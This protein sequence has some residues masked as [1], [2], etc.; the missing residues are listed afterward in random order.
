MFQNEFETFPLSEIEQK[1]IDDVVLQLKMLHIDNIV[2]FPF[3]TPP[4]LDQLE[5]AEKHLKLLEILDEKTARVTGLGRKVSQFPVTPRFGKMLV[6]GN[7]NDIL[8][9]VIIIVAALSVPVLFELDA[10]DSETCLEHRVIAGP[11]GSHGRKLGDPMLLLKMV[12]AGELAHS[13]GELKQFCTE[14]HIRLVP[15]LLF[16]CQ[17]LKKLVFNPLIFKNSISNRYKAFMEIRKLRH[18][19][20]EI[21]KKTFSKSS[22]TVDPLLLPP[23]EIKAR[24]LRQVILASSVDKIAR[25]IQTNDAKKEDRIKLKYGYQ[26]LDLEDPVYM[27]TDCVLIK[28]LPEYVCYQELYETNKLFMRNVTQIELEWIPV[29]AR[30]FFEIIIKA[31]WKI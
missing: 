2:N 28:Q 10:I 8:E 4:S 27:H 12:G 24:L 3:P 31:I 17:F 23:N 1:P 15:F 30:Y 7:D 25:K 13:K 26:T 20:T 19:L 6:F 16:F 29:Y 14:N 21:A 9:Y 11:K 18:Q 22:I 5:S